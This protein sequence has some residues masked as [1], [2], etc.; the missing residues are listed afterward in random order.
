MPSGV[1]D[2]GEES[3]GSHGGGPQIAAVTAAV[4]K[5]N[6]EGLVRMDGQGVGG[7]GR[8]EGGNGERRRGRMATSSQDQEKGE[9]KGERQGGEAAHFEEHSRRG[10]MLN[11]VDKGGG[12]GRNGHRFG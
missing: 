1:T 9:D 12:L 2:L 8:S 3:G 6:L 7:V 11:A 5:D 10:R 4:V